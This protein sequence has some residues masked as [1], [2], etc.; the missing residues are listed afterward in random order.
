MRANLIIIILLFAVVAG[1]AAVIVL[2]LS[3]PTF[4]KEG[5]PGK[6][7]A[8]QAAPV[9]AGG[10][11]TPAKPSAHSVEGA[12]GKGTGTPPG[13]EETP[14]G[15]QNGG[16]PPTEETPLDRFLNRFHE[17]Q[18]KIEWM[19]GEITM[20]LWGIFGE[21]VDTDE[22]KIKDGRTSRGKFLYKPGN[23]FALTMEAPS[24]GDE[25]ETERYLVYMHT[26]WVVTRK[27][28]TVKAERY[29]IEHEKLYE[30]LLVLQGADPAE[31]RK[32]FDMRLIDLG[33][34][35]EAKRLAKEGHNVKDLRERNVYFLEL[36]YK[37]RTKQGE[38]AHIEVVVSR[39]LAI[40]KAKFYK[41]N[42][43]ENIIWFSN[44]EINKGDEIPDSAF[45]FCPEKEGVETFDDNAT[46]DA[47]GGILARAR[48]TGTWV[49]GV[50]AGYES[51][52]F[53]ALWEEDLRH[54]RTSGALEFM[55]PDRFR[56][57]VTK[58]KE[59]V[60]ASNGR[61]V[62]IYEKEFGRAT[63]FNVDK[64]R[65]KLPLGNLKIMQMVFAQD[66]AA[67][68]NYFIFTLDKVEKIDG[69]ECYH[70]E[71]KP[72]DKA[73]RKEEDAEVYDIDHIELW[74]E[75]ET[76]LAHRARIYD[77]QNPDNY[78]EVTLADIDI[79]REIRPERFEVPEGV[80]ILEG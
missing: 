34:A 1:A 68:S 40:E 47:V 51:D 21:P 64:E 33:D 20:T 13:G 53:E 78:N 35:A 19:S 25:K 61:K 6:E 50:R 74:L 60:I 79:F 56:I 44:V 43:E 26:L 4:T 11:N 57:E 58:P 10:E 24:T 71:L 15:P 16:T 12:D 66:S 14:A 31:L 77:L 75:V 76:F 54:S 39:D 41:T 2:Q 42:D 30:M 62:F 80:E 45:R 23:R 69:V 3:T 5:A 48:M 72:L 49:K 73:Q 36:V 59:K 7:E 46:L 32:T 63:V 28:E 52:K 9:R 27:G 70:L 18:E 8:K 55:R 29:L 38:Y 17:G 65:G 22:E 67:L 37:D